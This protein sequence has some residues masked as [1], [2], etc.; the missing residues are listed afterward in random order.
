MA[1]RFDVYLEVAAKR[2]FAGALA[3]PGWSRSG[4]DE[5]SALEALAAYGPRYR[6]ALGRTA[7]AAT[8]RPPADPRAFRVAERV[9]G[10]ATTDFG[11]PGVAPAF[12]DRPLPPAEAKRLAAILRACW[13]AFDRTAEGA[14]GVPLRKGPR[15]GGREV[16]GIVRHV[17]EADAGY[18][19]A[20][21]SHFRKLDVSDM[22]A[23]MTAVRRALVDLL[24]SRARGEEAPRTPRRA[25]LWT[26]RYV[27]R[28]S[29]WHALDHAW[30]IE[31]RMEG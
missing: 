6:R 13:K 21:G 14:A 3:W 20:M 28:R 10:N 29:A 18:L 5:G 22:T 15:G 31:D 25:K 26:P 23:E 27:V 8:F 11:A 9:Q 19:Y 17:L 4:R 2:V 24:A 12:D 16:E 30:E 1:A 7:A